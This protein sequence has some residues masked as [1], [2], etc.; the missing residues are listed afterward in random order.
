MSK[1]ISFHRVKLHNLSAFYP[2]QNKILLKPRFPNPEPSSSPDP[3]SGT[4]TQAIKAPLTPSLKAPPD[5]NPR[6][7][8]PEPYS[9]PDPEP[10]SPFTSSLTAPSEPEP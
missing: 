2:K 3:E 10:R 1:I 5:P 8:N 9:S 7:P 4:Q 6:F